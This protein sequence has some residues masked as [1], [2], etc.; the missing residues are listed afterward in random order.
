MA[1]WGNTTGPFDDIHFY[2]P[3]VVNINGTASQFNCLEAESSLQIRTITRG[4]GR[5]GSRIVGYVMD[6]TLYVPQNKYD[7]YQEDLRKLQANDV[8]DIDIIWD[9]FHN[10]ETT[11]G[12][13]QDA[14]ITSNVPAKTNTVL[15][16]SCE[17]WTIETIERRPRIVLKFK[18][19][20]SVRLF[21]ATVLPYYMIY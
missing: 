5:G 21:E 10:D 11:F 17:G 7:L 19:I 4:R 20:Y 3:V 1:D 16:L 14:G 13:I 9:T 18:G 15:S 8:V 6:L 2:A 12:L